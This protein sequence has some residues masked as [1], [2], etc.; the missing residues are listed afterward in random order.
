MSAFLFDADGIAQIQRV[1][2]EIARNS[3]AG[4]RTDRTMPLLDIAEAGGADD[5]AGTWSINYG[6]SRVGTV[7]IR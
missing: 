1:N 7:T 5:D 6:G 2:D 3:R 4:K